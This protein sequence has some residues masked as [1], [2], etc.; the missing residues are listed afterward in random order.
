MIERL[1]R[2]P[3][4]VEILEDGSR[5]VEIKFKTFAYKILDP[6]LTNHSDEEYKFRCE[7]KAIG[8]V[9]RNE[10]TLAWI[11][12]DDENKWENQKLKEYVK[13]MQLL[14]LHIPKVEEMKTLLR[15]LHLKLDLPEPKDEEMKMKYA[16]AAL[17]YLTW[18]NWWYWLS[19]WNWESSENTSY[20]RSYFDWYWLGCVVCGYDTFY[21]LNKDILHSRAT[22]NILMIS[23]E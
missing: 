7:Y 21:L 8:W 19:M 23:R 18:I 3:V 2:I 17:M 4:N 1:E 10:V 6:N 5:L 14:W 22:G 9:N 15:R 13:Q 20:W 11:E 12:D 16:V